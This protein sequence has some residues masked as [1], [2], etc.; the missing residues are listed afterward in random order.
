MKHRRD[1][2]RTRTET[3]GQSLG[4]GLG[5]RQEAG[6]IPGMRLSTGT[7]PTKPR[8]QGQDLG[9]SSAGRAGLRRQGPDSEWSLGAWRGPR[10][11][12][13]QQ[14]SR[15]WSRHT[16]LECSCSLPVAPTSGRQA[17][18]LECHT[19]IPH[20][21]SEESLNSRT[22]PVGLVCGF[23]FSS[24]GIQGFSQT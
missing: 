7:T 15:N 21:P 10:V 1:R 6:I 8:T 13:S 18:A 3:Q 4:C 22:F 14:G 20:M 9:Q 11:E 5:H 17:G 16:H 2:Y 24:V 19:N 12:L 23:C